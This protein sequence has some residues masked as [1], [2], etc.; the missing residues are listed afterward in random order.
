MTHSQVRV[1]VGVFILSDPSSSSRHPAD[2]IFL[3]GKRLNSHG[4]NTLALPGGHLEPGETFSSCAIREVLEE[5]GLRV[6]D[7]RFLTATEDLF[8]S[9]PGSGGVGKHYVTVFVVCR[10]KDEEQRAEN[11]EPLK[12]GGWENMSWSQLG[13]MVRIDAGRVFTPLVNLLAQRPGMVPSL[14]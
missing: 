2:P 9:T 11:R 1:G 12:C 10:R 7:V 3:V 8:P 6:R 13:E 5:T 14:D 4:A